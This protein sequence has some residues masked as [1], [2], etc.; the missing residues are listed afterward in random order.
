MTLKS[1]QE[2]LKD[3]EIVCGPGDSQVVVSCGN[4]RFDISAIRTTH[5]SYVEGM[6]VT[7]MVFIDLKRL[8]NL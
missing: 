5:V 7:N 3:A 2:A 8:V 6:A 1:L 4:E